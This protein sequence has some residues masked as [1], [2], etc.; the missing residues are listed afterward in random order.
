MIVL[1]NF[2]VLEGI[3]GSGTTTLLKN[4]SDALKQKEV[5]S[6][7][8]C[9]PTDSPIGKEIRSV[10]RKEYKVEP[11]SLAQL[12]CVDRREHVLEIKKQLNRGRVICDRYLFSSL[13]Y[14]SLDCGWD[15]IWEWNQDFPLP[16][17]LVFLDLPAETAQKRMQHRGEETE[18]FE[19]LSMQD[20]IIRN[21]HRAID[22]F[23]DSPMDIQRIDGTLP[24]EE[25]CLK[26]LD[27]I[28]Q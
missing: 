25:I 8:T 6:F 26:V 4:L 11:L 28:L 17:K 22:F 13:A 7:E 19:N 14:Q 21:Y 2:I 5:I 1:K 15:R 9:E 23:S 12:F 10:L 16:E 24:A 18:L 20:K 3:D 27:F